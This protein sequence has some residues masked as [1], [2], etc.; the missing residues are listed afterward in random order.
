MAAAADAEFDWTNFLH[1]TCRWSPT[2]S[3]GALYT[4]SLKVIGKWV[5]SVLTVI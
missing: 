3:G 2:G 5:L 1:F 4:G